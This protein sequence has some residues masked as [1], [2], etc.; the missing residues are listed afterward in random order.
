M[1]D[2][3]NGQKQISVFPIARETLY[4]DVCSSECGQA[5]RRENAS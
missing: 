2:G 1:A 4:V 3:E 5:Q